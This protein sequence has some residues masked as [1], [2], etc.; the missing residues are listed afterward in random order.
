MGAVALLRDRS[1]RVGAAGVVIAAAGVVV[2]ATAGFASGEVGGRAVTSLPAAASGPGFAGGSGPLVGSAFPPLTGV[3]LDG[4]P[5][6]TRSRGK[7]IVVA[8]WD[9]TCRCNAIFGAANAVV[10]ES[11]PGV[12]IVGVSLDRDVSKAA[13]AN[14]DAGLLFPSMTEATGSVRR[15]VGATPYG[16]LVVV[17]SDGNV[18]A[19]FRDGVGGGVD[20]F[21]ADVNALVGS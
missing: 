7:P 5:V 2:L 10:L 6:S 12:D 20:A 4:R 21:V 14:L 3:G 19:D 8:I 1:I 17:D 16:A 15:L 9:T 13:Q 18:V 11:G